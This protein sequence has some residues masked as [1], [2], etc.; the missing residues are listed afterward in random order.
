MPFSLRNG[1][2]YKKKKAPN[3]SLLSHFTI[4]SSLPFPLPHFFSFTKFTNYIYFKQLCTIIGPKKFPNNFTHFLNPYSHFIRIKSQSKAWTSMR[5]PTLIRTHFEI[6]ILSVLFLNRENLRTFLKF[7][8]EQKKHKIL[9][10]TD[11]PETPLKSVDF[12]SRWTKT[13]PRHLLQNKSNYH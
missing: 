7:S 5:I 6:M 11:I 1:K 4:S 13:Q 9:K 8:Q 3:F 2:G 12:D 10:R